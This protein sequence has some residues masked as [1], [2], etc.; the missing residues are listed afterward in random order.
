MTDQIIES[1]ISDLLSF[2]KAQLRYADTLS[3]TT[4]DRFNIFNVLGIGHLEVRTHSPILAE[5]L[6]PRGSHS[7]GATF[8]KLFVD[9][10]GVDDFRSDSATVK[11]E[12]HVGPV[13]EKSGGRVDIL[14]MDGTG[15]TILIENKIYA[16]DQPNQIA[17]YRNWNRQSRIFYLTLD[18]R[19]PSGVLDD[20]TDGPDFESI[21]YEKNIILWLDDCRGASACLPQVRETLTQYINLLKELTNQLSSFP[22]KQELIDEI[23]KSPEALRAYFTLRNADHEVHAALSNILDTQLV[24]L[25]AATGLELSAPIW[26]LHRKGGGFSFT[27]PDLRSKNLSI[28]FEFGA[29]SYSQFFFGFAL[30]D[31]QLPGPNTQSLALAFK[32]KFTLGEPSPVWPAWTSWPEYQDWKPETFEAIRS[33]Q[34]S[35]DLKSKLEMLA[36]IATQISGA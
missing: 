1:K 23:L 13:T 20:T 12:Y 5:L 22:M 29:G 19:D 35:E 11:S 10:F 36:D 26:D 6:N 15:R 31:V 16:G 14:I 27:T 28:C 4:G 2:T 17:R 33:G 9:R 32:Q 8:L 21:S 18:G 25:A 3:Q 34:F 24:S 30:I 7:Q